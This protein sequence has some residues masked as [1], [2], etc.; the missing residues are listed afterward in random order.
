MAALALA[1]FAPVALSAPLSE[2]EV[3]PVAEQGMTRL[4]NGEPDA[5]IALFKQVEKDDPSSPLGCVLEADAIWWKIYYSTAD[6]IDP[7]VFD[8]VTSYQT[9][10]D[11][12]FERVIQTAIQKSEANI[13]ARRDVARNDLY[14]GMSYA[15][16]A[17]LQGLRARDMATARAGKKMR[18][19]LLTALQLDPNL[20]DAYAGTGLYNYFVDT[21]P[22]IVKMLRFLIG[23]PGGN[24]ALGI[25]QMQKAAQSGDFTRAEAKFYLAKDY[26]RR[27][28]MQFSKALDLFQQLASEYPKNPFWQLM[29]ASCQMRLGQ[30]RQG[31]ALY[32]QVLSQTANGRSLADQS[33]HSQVV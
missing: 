13:H 24:R 25:E 12:A 19:L 22:A 2:A 20:T 3:Q 26:T 15:L 14:E 11:A 7:D 28:E 8:V 10:Y 21:L 6:L 31:E 18:S 17:R 5:A 9:P 16:E 27:N 4:M 1:M 23:L 32:R 30:T 29:V 33:V